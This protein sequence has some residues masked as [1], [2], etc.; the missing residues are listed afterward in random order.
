M[1]SGPEPDP[2]VGSGRKKEAPRTQLFSP[3][4]WEAEMGEQSGELCA[5]PR[6]WV[7][8]GLPAFPPL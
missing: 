7:T 8:T 2:G 1:D 3:W 6:K 5:R 4:V